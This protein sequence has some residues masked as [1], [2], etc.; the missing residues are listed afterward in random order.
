MIGEPNH[1]VAGQQVRQALAALV[2]RQLA[3]ILAVEAEQ[4]IGDE[5]RVLAGVP[6]AQGVEVRAPV[7]Q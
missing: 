6:R 2:E 4:V 7:F 5:A 1:V 3:E